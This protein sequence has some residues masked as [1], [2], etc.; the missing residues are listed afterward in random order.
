MKET[1]TCVRIAQANRQ[2][3]TI[4]SF[5]SASAGHKLCAGEIGELA[6]SRPS[7]AGIKPYIVKAARCVQCLT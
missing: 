5:A 2:L 7:S 3:A 1:V 6:H 4:A